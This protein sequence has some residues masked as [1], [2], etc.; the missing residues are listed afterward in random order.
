MFFEREMGDDISPLLL[1]PFL[2]DFQKKQYIRERERE[3]ERERAFGP[4][5]FLF[6]HVEETAE[7]VFHS[8]SLIFRFF[9]VRF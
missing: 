6:F 3:R 1:S 9:L 2:G 5:E 8:F 4:F 7:V